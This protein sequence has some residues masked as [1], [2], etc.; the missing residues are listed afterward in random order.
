MTQTPFTISNANVK[1]LPLA[2]NIEQVFNATFTDTYRTVLRGGASEPFYRPADTD[3]DLHSIVYREDF[4]A[5]SLHE[6]AHWLVAGDA[7]RLLPDWGYWYAPDGRNAVQQQQFQQVEVKPQALEW[8]LHQAC[9]LHFRVS[10]DNLGAEAGDG[11]AFKD[12]VYLQ[13]FCYVA[14]GVND[15]TQLFFGAL[16]AAFDGPAD[17]R[18]LQLSRQELDE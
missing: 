14:E 8:L 3:S 1:R 10:L 17:I 7:R 4:V 11:Q 16:S 2:A 6:T 9:G 13:A 12:A 15:R 18:Q 5:S